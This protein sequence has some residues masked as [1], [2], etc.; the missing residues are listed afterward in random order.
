ML[1]EEKRIVHAVAG[2]RRA[3][4]RAGVAFYDAR[5]DLRVAR[6]PTSSSPRPAGAP[7]DINLYQAQKTLD[8]VAGAVRD[9]GAII[10]V[11][12]CAEG[13]ATRSSSGGWRR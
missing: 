2:D 3:A 13:S 11:A 5:C 9:G 8:N 1:D 4:H 10:L 12:E 7:K 6:P